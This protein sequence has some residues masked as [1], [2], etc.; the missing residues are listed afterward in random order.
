MNVILEG[1]D[2]G[3]PVRDHPY[4][5]SAYDS[6]VKH[7]DFVHRPEL[8]R[9]ALEDFKPWESYEAV[10]WF[11][12]MLEWINGSESIFETSDC[13]LEAPKKNPHENMSCDLV[14]RGRLMVFFRDIPLN[15]AD[16]VSESNYLVNQNITDVAKSSY[17]YLNNE[18]KEIWWVT[19]Q[20]FFFPTRYRNSSPPDAFGQQVVFQFSCF[21][22][23]EEE[24][25]EAFKF[26]ITSIF[27]AV[28][29]ANAKWTIA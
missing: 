17:E 24:S 16:I 14:V 12:Q 3:V 13:R 29:R 1:V 4:K 26:A 18:Y 27:G 8:I 19:I 20:I 6:R 2:P 21:G 9:Q 7:Y 15:Y 25:F 22:D 10:D 23:S 11:Y 5:G 28:K